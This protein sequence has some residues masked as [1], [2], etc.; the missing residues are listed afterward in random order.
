MTRQQSDLIA[1]RISALIEAHARL[2]HE[3]SRPGIDGPDEGAVRRCKRRIAEAEDFLS[4]A[5]AGEP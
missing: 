1:I 4:E 5:I 2:A 3:E